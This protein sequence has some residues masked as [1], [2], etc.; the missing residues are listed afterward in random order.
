MSPK[1][2][3]IVKTYGKDMIAEMYLDLLNLTHNK[4]H[5]KEGGRH[6]KQHKKT[7]NV[8]IV[9]EERTIKVQEEFDIGDHNFKFVE[10]SMFTQTQTL[11]AKQGNTRNYGLNTVGIK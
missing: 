8:T 6:K 3:Q 10:S 5:S 1:K 9:S 4:R 11:K 2:K 7:N